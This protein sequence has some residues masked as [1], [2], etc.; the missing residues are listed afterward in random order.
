MG[1]TLWLVTQCR[2]V[3]VVFT[4]TLLAYLWTDRPFAIIKTVRGG[5]PPIGPPKFE[6]PVRPSSVNLT[7]LGL[8]TLP[9]MSFGETMQFLGAG[10]IV[11]GVVSILQN[12]AICKAWGNGKT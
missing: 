4:T 12:V 3:L 1:K 2:N 11:I 8:D 7:E 5:F 10:P 9:V 6:L